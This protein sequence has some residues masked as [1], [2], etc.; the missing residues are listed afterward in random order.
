MVLN[1]VKKFHKILIKSAD[2]VGVTYVGPTY[3]Q[4]YVWTDRLTDSQW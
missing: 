2:V 4:T 3:V 1:N